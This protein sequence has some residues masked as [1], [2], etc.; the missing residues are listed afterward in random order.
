M[1]ELAAVEPDLGELMRRFGSIQ[2]R[3]S[4]TVGGNIA[5]GSPIGDLPPALIALGASLEL[6]GRAGRRTMPLEDFFLAYR[7]QDRRPGEYVRRILVPR[8]RSD[9]V[10]RAYKVT[11]RI[12]E[13]ISAALGAFKFTLDGRRIAEARVAYGGM[14]GTPKRALATEGALRGADLDREATWEPALAALATDYSPLTD[15]RATAA[16]RALVARNLLFKALME[17]RGAPRSLMRVIE[18]QGLH[19]AA[20]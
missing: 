14:A 2:V 5:N 6:A 3:T 17:T 9:E 8:L 10:F 4:G 19:D 20:A 16:Y 12:D 7:K 18:P 1:A 11:K 15:H 13:D